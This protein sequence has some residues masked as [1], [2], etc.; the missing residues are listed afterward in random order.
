MRIYVAMLA[1]LPILA[2]AQNLGTYQITAGDLPGDAVNLVGNITG[3][4][5]S[6]TLVGY[7]EPLYDDGA[8]GVSGETDFSMAFSAPAGR[9][10]GIYLT[11][12][13]PSDLSQEG[14]VPTDL[15]GFLSLYAK[16]DGEITTPLM[17]ITQAG[18]YSVPFA[19]SADVY[20][21]A[22]GST[23]P[24][25]YADFVGSGTLTVDV[26]APFCA[27]GACGPMYVT[28]VDYH[29]APELDPASLSG[30]VT[31]LVGSVMVLRGRRSR[32][33]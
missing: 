32:V 27:D 6:G 20:Y 22:P 4:S 28:S 18:T 2:G 24:T 5:F 30:A 17:D 14:L 33:S 29:F 9:D 13:E 11:I 7:P 3:N 25:G 15:P 19:M 31:L 16:E 12:S 21:G 10:F 26:A 1:L 23:V 8:A